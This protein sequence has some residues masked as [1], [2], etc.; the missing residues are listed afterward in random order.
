MKNVLQNNISLNFNEA[1]FLIL[2]IYRKYNSKI[3]FEIKDNFCK[4]VYIDVVLLNRYF[5]SV[6]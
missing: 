4:F 1:Y 3:I 5:L 6:F 2:I